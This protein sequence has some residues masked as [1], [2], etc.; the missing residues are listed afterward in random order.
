MHAFFVV[1]ASLVGRMYALLFSIRNSGWQKVC[2]FCGIALE[3]LEGESCGAPQQSVHIAHNVLEVFVGE[4][5]GTPQ[6]NCTNC[7]H[8][9]GS[10]ERAGQ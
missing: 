1:S 9:E 7:G 2:I 8:W 3:V 10:P 4:S 5:Y 6:T